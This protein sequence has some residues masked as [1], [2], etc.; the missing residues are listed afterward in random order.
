MRQGNGTNI[1]WTVGPE[2]A[3][4]RI[5]QARQQEVRDDARAQRRRDRHQALMLGLVG[6]LF[7]MTGTVVYLATAGMQYQVHLVRV[8]H[9]GREQGVEQAPRQPIKPERT[10]VLGIIQDWIEKVRWITEDRR[11][12]DLMWERVEDFATASTMRQLQEFR[13][14]QRARQLAGRRVQ[15]KFDGMPAPVAQKS[16]SYTLNWKEE[17]FDIYGN[18]LVEECGYW[19]AILTI[20]DFQSK[21]AQQ[22]LDLRRRR[23]NWRNVYGVF[24]DGVTWSSKPLSTPTGR[25]S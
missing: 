7:L 1:E 15:I 6:A 17:A 14:E 23:Q 4:D 19:S 5:E 10:V 21:A 24:V 22:E 12:F 2:A 13:Q 11:L 9:L 18:K 16:Q 20:A 8:D 25:E 3:L